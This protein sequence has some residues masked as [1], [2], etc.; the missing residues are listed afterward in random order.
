MA[1]SKKELSKDIG[2]LKKKAKYPEKFKAQ[3]GAFVRTLEDISYFNEIL[4]QTIP[5]GMDIVSQDGDVLFQN[6]KL[7]I[8]FG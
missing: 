2:A 4:I 1:D 5:F 7:E 6:K 8:L 3:Y